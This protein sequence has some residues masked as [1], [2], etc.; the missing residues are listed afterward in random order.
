MSRSG[1]QGSAQVFA[2][3]VNHP[4][5]K[6]RRFDVAIQQKWDREF[7]PIMQRAIDAEL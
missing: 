5:T 4:G 2:R 6:A 1:S 7:G 3:G